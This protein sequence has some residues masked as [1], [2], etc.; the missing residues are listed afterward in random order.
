[1]ADENEGAAAVDPPTE[2]REP[3]TCQLHIIQAAQV[4]WHVL[5]GTLRSPLQASFSI[6]GRCV[7]LSN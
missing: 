7:S 1:M 5:L 6:Y 3:A 2:L 4:R